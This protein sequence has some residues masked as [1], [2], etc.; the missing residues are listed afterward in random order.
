MLGYKKKFDEL[1][2][3]FD[4]L[5][6]SF[7]RLK[8][9]QENPPKYTVGQNTKFGKCTKAY[10]NHRHEIVGDLYVRFQKILNWEYVFENKNGSVITIT[11]K[12]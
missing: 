2:K 5:R 12:E 1:K 8:Y 11:D 3:E 10:I 6:D 7:D 4:S 9:A